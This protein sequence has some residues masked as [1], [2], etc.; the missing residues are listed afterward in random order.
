[1]SQLWVNNS[2]T[3]VPI[4]QIYLKQG[5]WFLVK[6]VW[7]NSGG[8]WI[9]G[10][11][12]YITPLLDRNVTKLTAPGQLATASYTLASDGTASSS[13]NFDGTVS[14][15]TPGSAAPNYECL[16]TLTSGTLTTGTAGSWLALSASRVWSV[17]RSNGSK[18]CIFTVQIRRIGT[19]TVLTS[20]TI[21]LTANS[22][23]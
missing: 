22:P 20:A 15:V 10:G 11:G 3:W 18:E 9:Q 5:A 12:E 14:W 7:I 17:S 16:A 23:P 6:G 2:G 19:S 8:T 4:K 13:P 1:M 21:D